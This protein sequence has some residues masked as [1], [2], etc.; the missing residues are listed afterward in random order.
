MLFWICIFSHCFLVLL[1]LH[2]VFITCLPFCKQFRVNIV[3]FW[4]WKQFF[5]WE[6]NSNRPRTHSCLCHWFPV[7]QKF[8][9]FFF[10]SDEKFQR[11][12][13]KTNVLWGIQMIEMKYD[14]V[15]YTHCYSLSFCC[16]IHQFLW[17][18]SR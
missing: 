10:F 16:C 2:M 15:K 3:Q 5:N 18:K 12:Y 4:F 6:R 7:F 1:R 9:L 11:S 14:V 13:N 8:N 17:C